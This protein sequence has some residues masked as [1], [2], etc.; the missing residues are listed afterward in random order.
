MHF[1]GKKN[2][3]FIDLTEKYWINFFKNKFTLRD[4]LIYKWVLLCKLL[5]IT[6]IK[7]TILIKENE[8][9]VST[10]GCNYCAE[11]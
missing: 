1:G 9:I 11:N 2:W 7:V 6:S 4:C 5:T 10:T 8:T 3:L